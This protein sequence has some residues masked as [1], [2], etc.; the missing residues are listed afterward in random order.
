[1]AILKL[2]HVY[3]KI[4]LIGKYICTFRSQLW[5]KENTNWECRQ[6]QERTLELELELEISV[7]TH[8]ILKSNNYLF[9]C[10]LKLPSINEQSVQILVSNTFVH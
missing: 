1:M 8:G 9:F 7:R 10:P 3:C 2:F 6:A 5:E 4:E